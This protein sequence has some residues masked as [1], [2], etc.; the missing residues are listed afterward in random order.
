MK[1][2][3]PEILNA[4]RRTD[5]GFAR[6]EVSGLDAVLALPEIGVE[7]PLAEVYDGVRFGPDGVDGEE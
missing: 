4:Y 1:E 5:R 2:T 6:E 7:L 3:C